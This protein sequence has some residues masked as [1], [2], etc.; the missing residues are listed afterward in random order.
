MS[1]LGFN[2]WGAIASAVGIIALIPV[3][4]VWLRPRM[5]RAVLPSVLEVHK[6]AKELLET[7]VKEG[8]ITSSTDLLDFNVNLLEAAIRVDA[9]RAE[10]YNIKSWKRDA[11]KWWSGL[12]VDMFILREDLNSMRIK[13]AQRS[14]DERKRLASLGLANEFSVAPEYK[15]AISSS[16]SPVHSEPTRSPPGC[17]PG[18]TCLSEE[19]VDTPTSNISP[20]DLYGEENS[21]RRQTVPDQPS[22]TT[23][24]GE[25]G[26][27]GDP[28]SP[29]KHHA[30]LSRSTYHLI[31]DSDLQDL[32]SLA[33][34][35]PHHS[36]D[37]SKRLR[38]HQAQKAGKRGR[39]RS[40]ST[41]GGGDSAFVKRRV[42][43]SRLRSLLNL[44]RRVYGVQL[45][46][47]DVSQP[48]GAEI[49]IALGLDPESLTPRY[50]EEGDSDDESDGWEE[51]Q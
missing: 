40:V 1:D 22:Q 50:T 15:D 43:P 10:V 39:G 11:Q 17:N 21:P 16:P 47:Q 29:E 32:L 14:S 19:R 51:C 5:P 27:T 38:P 35:L 37:D 6:E 2:V 49:P 26:D 28:V 20:H 13:L 24:G 48:S 30:T 9:M 3:F 46:P 12:S 31:P 34:T 41:K 7:A 23:S 18:A 25:C 36:L 4:L 8:L 33:F 42:L 44:V 45:G